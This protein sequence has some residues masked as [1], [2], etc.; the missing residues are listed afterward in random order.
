MMRTFL[1]GLLAFTACFTARA[2]EPLT[3][4][5]DSVATTKKVAAPVRT[6]PYTNL[7]DKVPH[8]GY[9]GSIA[10][11][12]NAPGAYPGAAGGFT[13]THGYMIRPTVFLGAGAGYIHSFSHSAGVIPV[14]AEGRIYFPSEYMRRIYPHIGARLGGQI[15]TKGGSG[16]YVQVACAF[17]I[18]FSDRV[19][20]N[21][22]VGPQYVGKYE[23]EA[24]AGTVTFNQDFKAKGGH[25]GFFGRVS[26]EF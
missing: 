8:S 16:M 21:V 22:E 5:A 10:L 1:L 3:V 20:L 9:V 14:Y 6:K 12:I 13:T 25:F 26:F 19:A 17:R 15:G 23:R 7:Y 4:A 11:E 2:A 18:P 24:A